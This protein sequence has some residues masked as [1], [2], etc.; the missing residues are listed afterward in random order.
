MKKLISSICIALILTFGSI[1]A[2]WEI[3]TLSFD[4]DKSLSA[5]YKI[6]SS[7]DLKMEIDSEKSYTGKCVKITANTGDSTDEWM[8]Y[9]LDASY[10]HLASFAG[11]KI[12]VQ[13][14]FPSGTNSKMS[15]F[16]LFATDPSYIYDTADTTITGSWQTLSISVPSDSHN[17]SLGFKTPVNPNVS[18]VVCYI[19]DMRITNKE[20]TLVASVDFDQAW[21][22]DGT[23][24]GTNTTI[25]QKDSEDEEN[26]SDINSGSS[27]IVEEENGVPVTLII[28]L[29]SLVVVV[30]TALIIWIVVSKSKNK[31]Y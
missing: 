7:V 16:Q 31:Y 9:E 6:D 27:I 5:F 14:Y 2:A 26:V 13:V 15:Y 17:K 20:G 4:T 8:G 19:D 11:C 28:I 30:I 25:A 10:F 1:A 22:D 24:S 23:Y 18:D 3:P 12:E 21:K 29:V